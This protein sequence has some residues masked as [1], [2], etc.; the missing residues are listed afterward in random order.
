MY[1]AKDLLFRFNLLGLDQGWLKIIE[2]ELEEDYFIT[3]LSGLDEKYKTRT[4]YP[5]QDQIFR[6]LKESPFHQVKLIIIGQDPYHGAGQA[7]GL[8]FS[9]K[10]GTKIPPSLRNIFQ[11]IE[12]EYGVKREQTDLR[13]WAQQGVLLLNTV[14]TVEEGRANS[15]SQLGWEKFTDKLIKKLN[16]TRQ[17]KVFI[18]WGNHAGS[19]ARFID[20]ERHF[21]LRS[22]HPSPL[23]AY[24]GFIGNDHFKKANNFLEEK[25]LEKII[26]I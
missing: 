21:V 4:I 15:H 26:W 9:V 12:R 22:A 13:D 25:K 18:L 8:A 5:A 3:L 23:S 11:E 19:K 2:E 16:E 17:S 7:N 20:E 10:E 1:K 24:R 14:L 6:A